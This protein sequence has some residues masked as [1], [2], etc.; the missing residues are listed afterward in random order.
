MIHRAIPL[1]AFS[2]GLHN[3]QHYT[4]LKG[5]YVTANATPKDNFVFPEARLTMT[6]IQI[7]INYSENFT[8]LHK[9][10]QESAGYDLGW[11]IL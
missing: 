10:Q 11:Y 2:E 5:I 3:L 4:S 9:L 8:K 6:A 1:H 7:W